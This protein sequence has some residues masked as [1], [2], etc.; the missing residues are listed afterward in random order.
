MKKKYQLYCLKDLLGTQIYEN[1][2]FFLKNCDFLLA[3]AVNISGGCPLE[4]KFKK[5]FFFQSCSK[6]SKTSRKLKKN[7]QKKFFSAPGAGRKRNFFKKK[8]L[9]SCIWVP[10]RS[11]KR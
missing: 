5:K 8:F 2:N 4:K 6:P 9:F 1:K 10:N 7:F 11:F 3:P